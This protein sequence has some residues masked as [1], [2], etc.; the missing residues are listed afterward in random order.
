MT[1]DTKALILCQ[2]DSG[3][4]CAAC[5][6]LY[7]FVD[8]S[9]EALTRRLRARS[10][11]FRQVMKTG[12]DIAD[13]ARETLAKEDLRKRYEIIHCCEYM[14]FLDEQEK[15]VGVFCIRRR[16]QALISGPVL[17][18]GRSFAPDTFVQATNIFL[19]YNRRS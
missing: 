19:R 4:S 6:G 5:C 16:I 1:A 11:R 3:K 12:G 18:T 17:F 2:P 7:N 13:Y 9:R 8:S 15:R 10:R 14:G